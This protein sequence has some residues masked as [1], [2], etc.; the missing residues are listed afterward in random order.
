M[1]FAEIRK[2][3]VAAAALIATGAPQLLVYGDILPQWVA[4]TITILTILAG[5][6]GVWAA[7]N[8]PVSQK[9]SETLYRAQDLI[10]I[11]R[12]IVREETRPVSSPTAT[13]VSP[14]VEAKVRPARTN[15]FALPPLG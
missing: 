10:P 12:D 8:K 7:P 6:V 15:P 1:T 9:V 3:V 11:V 13:G 14:A 2:A 4:I 5:I